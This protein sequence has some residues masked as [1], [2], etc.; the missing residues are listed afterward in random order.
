MTTTQLRI[1]LAAGIALCAALSLPSFADLKVKDAKKAPAAPALCAVTGEEVS[2]TGTPVSHNGKQYALCCA[3]CKPQFE[4]NPA[5]YSKMGDLRADIRATELKLAALKQELTAT[6]KGSGA[7]AAATAAPAKT[8]STTTA[9]E[10]FCAV[11]DSVIP[12]DK[13]GA[14][15]A[16]YNGKTYDLCCAGCKAKFEKD[17]AKSAADADE[18]A[19]KRAAAK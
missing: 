4:K 15:T 3:G 11:R 2:G 18:R 6:E 14:I 16:S 19:V 5:K 17:P 10:A 8:G 12:A 9:A 13:V 7:A 1:T